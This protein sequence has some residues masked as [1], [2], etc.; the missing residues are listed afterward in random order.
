MRINSINTSNICMQSGKNPA[1]QS[2]SAPIADKQ[3]KEISTGQ[4]IGVGIG[5]ISVIALGIELIG[6][7][8]RHLKKLW[9]SFCRENKNN[10]I[11][12]QEFKSIDKAKEY[13]ETLGVKTVFKEG[14]QNHLADL[15]NIKKDLITLEKN[16]VVLSKPNSV[17]LCNWSNLEEVKQVLEPLNISEETANL[18]NK[19]S[20]FWGTV[21]KSSDD[22]YHVLINTGFNGDYGRFIHEMG[23]IHQD[24]LNSSYWGSKGLTGEEFMAKQME[25]LGLSDI[26]ISSAYINM[27]RREKAPLLMLRSA[28]LDIKGF[29]MARDKAM[30]MFDNI[31]EEDYSKI[32]M[33]FGA[34]EKTYYLNAKKM[35]DKMAGESG[36]YAPSKLWENVAEI[37]Q[38]LNQGKEYSDLVMLMYDI[39]GGGRVPNRVIKGMKYDNY[40]ESLYKNEDLIRQLRECI[41]IK[42][43]S[44]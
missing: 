31:K 5:I 7:K 24:Y 32:F 8:G 43:P 41:E 25:I 22:K 21:A 2:M 4:K 18:C 26:G 19:S 12:M 33:I 29:D 23:H 39:S 9:G 40:I 14:S 1:L 44:V 15:N 20:G 27:L 6:C 13:F 28:S 36:V 3:R 34:D 17:I 37:F 16:G 10:K 30:R 42:S 11:K 38:G 35:V